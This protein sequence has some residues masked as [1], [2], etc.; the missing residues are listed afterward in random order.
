ML[1]RALTEIAHSQ[2]SFAS[3]PDLIVSDGAGG[4]TAGASQSLLIQSSSDHNAG[5]DLTLGNDDFSFGTGVT[6]GFG[7]TARMAQQVLQPDFDPNLV[8]LFDKYAQGS[9]TQADIGMGDTVSVSIGGTTAQA[10]QA[11][12]SSSF[13]FADFNGGGSTVRLALPVAI[14]ETA[15]G[16]DDQTAVVRLRQNGQDTLAI[17]FYEVDDL[18]GTIDGLAPGS[19]GYAAAAAARAYDVMSG[20]TIVNGPGYGSYGQAALKHVDAGD[21]VAMQLINSSHGDAYWAFS[22]ANPDGIGHLWNYGANTWGW[23]DTRGGGDNDFNDMIV[24]LDFTS[25]AGHGWLV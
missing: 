16:A 11:G 3:S 14:A 10:P 15:G 5:V 23:E 17:R 25:A 22:Q 20:G 24:Q 19:A 7:W 13:G 4:W 9:V 6:S 2:V 18:N 21:I 12:L 1:A 8:R